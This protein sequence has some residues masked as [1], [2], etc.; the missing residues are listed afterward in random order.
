MKQL[1]EKLDLAESTISQYETEKRSPDNETLLKLAE[2][3]GVSVGYI[4]GNNNDSLP[5]DLYILIGKRIVEAAQLKGLSAK[6]ILSSIGISSATADEMVAGSYP[7]TIGTLSQ[8]A[9]CFDK[10]IQYF[11]APNT[12]NPTP[13]SER[14]V[15]DDTIKAAFFDG[16]DPNLTKEEM[17]AMWEDARTYMQFKL[18]QRKRQKNEQ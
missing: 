5:P 14:T 9:C 10:P 7:F 13:E 16:A 4:L 18:E 11:L 8:I 6:E 2:Y 17:D 1:G 15:S 3:F 12:E